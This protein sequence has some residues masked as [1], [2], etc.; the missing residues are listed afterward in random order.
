MKIFDRLC[1]WFAPNVPASHV[2]TWVADGGIQI[3]DADKGVIQYFFSNNLDDEQTLELVRTHSKVVYRSTWITDSALSRTRQPLGSYAL[4][5]ARRTPHSG[6]STRRMPHAVVSDRR[7]TISRPASYYPHHG[8][9]P[10]Y[11][12]SLA[13]RPHSE[14]Y[15]QGE[16]PRF[17]DAGSETQSIRSRCS[18][19]LSNSSSVISGRRQHVVSRFVI[20]ADND[21]CRSILADVADFEP[22][23]NGFVAYKIPKLA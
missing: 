8:A 21:T 15:T 18:S 7:A 10:E 23:A 2:T 1:A 22:N 16:M 19:R 9:S 17:W 3:R 4:T 20:H 13:R 5:Q 12:Q 11:P 14:Y 6:A